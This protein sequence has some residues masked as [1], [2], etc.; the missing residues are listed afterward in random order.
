MRILVLILL[1][2]L[3]FESFLITLRAAPFLVPADIP[4]GTEVF[5]ITDAKT[6]ATGNITA[7]RSIKDGKIIQK[8][9]TQW[10]SGETLEEAAV[11]AMSKA[12]VPLSYTK[13]VKNKQGNV[14]LETTVQFNVSRKSATITQKSDERN[15]TRS[16]DIPEDCYVPMMTWIALQGLKFSP[17]KKYKFHI[18][19][20]ISDPKVYKMELKILGME[21]VKVPAGS[22]D[23]YKI[24]MK[25]DFGRFRNLFV[26]PFAPETYF[27][28]KAT[29][30]H[31]FMKYQGV[32]YS[33]NKKKVLYE[34]VESEYKS[35]VE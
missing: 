24:E 22:F 9:T 8:A 13:L 20:L 5:R 35:D 29:S 19:A 28:Q 30:P 18:L 33:D 6:N 26:S 32:S 15:F 10:Q 14:I 11:M 21:Q 3:L 27:W 17:G 16:I 1:A 4:S 23:G 34:L 25:H 7:V 12:L 2:F 31:Q